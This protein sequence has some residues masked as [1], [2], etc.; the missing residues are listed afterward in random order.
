MGRRRTSTS[1]PDSSVVDGALAAM[2]A[3]EL[4]ELVRDML[5][6]LD[7]RAHARILNFLIDRA[8]RNDSGWTPA[9][10]SEESVSSIVAFAEAAKRVG[11]ADPSEVD[12]YLLQGTN[13]FLGKD[14]LVAFKIFRALLLPICDGDIDLG[15]HEMVDEILSVDVAACAAQY[16]VATYMTAVPEQ[17]AEA[18]RTAIDEVGGFGNF[19]EPLREMDRV[20]IEPLPQ[21]DDFI[22]RW[23]ALIEASCGSARRNDW[24]TERDGWLREAVQRMEGSDGLARLARSTRRG[25]DLR[26]WCLMLVEARDWKAA[27]SA[28]EEAAQIV[29]PKRYSRGEFLDGAALAA[30]K[31]G[32]KDLPARFEHAWRE[33]PSMLRLRR[34]L[35]TSK[36]KATLRKRASRALDVCPKKAT[37]QRAF[38]HVILGDATSAA[39]LLAA[40]PGLGWSDGEHPGHLLFPLFHAMLGGSAL[41]DASEPV[42]VRRMA[43]DELVWLTTARDEPRLAAPEVDEILKLAGMGGFVNADAR[44]VLLGAM[45]RAAE[46]R[47]AGVTKNKRRRYYWHAAKL[48]ASC[49]ALNSSRETVRWVAGMRKEYRRYPALQGEFDHHIGRS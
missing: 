46:K 8:A 35:G 40:A 12:D 3:V 48:V 44:R 23:R 13:A 24:G 49:A 11:Y 6:E 7:E 29:A 25:D 39:K 9:G 32:R 33:A 30:Q 20:A 21:L 38:L 26:A 17:R 34:W 10:P 41:P 31:L 37:R 5:L 36:N 18:A 16:V 43:I 1:K 4:R 27:L 47:V 19:W 15:Q 22:S 14:Y 42:S 45:R 28:Y 2:S